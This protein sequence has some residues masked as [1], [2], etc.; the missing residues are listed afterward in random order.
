MTIRFTAR[1][2]HPWAPTGWIWVVV[3]DS[4]DELQAAAKRYSADVDHSETAACFQ[5]RAFTVHVDDDGRLD[6][7]AAPYAG[8]MRLLPEHGVATLAHECTHA[9]LALYQRQ[10][11]TDV[12]MTTGGMDDEEVLCYA[13]G[14]LVGAITVEL[15]ARGIWP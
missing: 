7:P 1:T 8:V 5:G 2:T 3:H 15:K 4:A 11:A 14:D 12:G 9:A 10:H 6:V 13:V